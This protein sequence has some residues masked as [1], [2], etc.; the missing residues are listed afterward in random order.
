MIVTDNPAASICAAM[1][2]AISKLSASSRSNTRGS[3][4]PHPQTV[5][6]GGGTGGG[7]GINTLPRRGSRD[8]LCPDSSGLGYGRPNTMPPRPGTGASHPN[9]RVAN[10]SPNGHPLIHPNDVDPGGGGS[11]SGGV[12][13]GGNVRFHGPHSATLQPS[14]QQLFHPVL[15]CL[16]ANNRQTTAYERVTTEL[17]GRK[18][19]DGGGLSRKLSERVRARQNPVR[20]AGNRVRRARLDSN[21]AGLLIN[22]RASAG[23]GCTV[24]N[25]P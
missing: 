9:L 17:P 5:Q 24:W 21:Q 19:D 7:L 8:N 23:R 22:F 11:G 4:R 20:T 25:Q 16:P 15:A 13:G 1:L 6:P 3:R 2:S 14:R 18:K 10:K 12:R